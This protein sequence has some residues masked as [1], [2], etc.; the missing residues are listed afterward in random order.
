MV[1]AA[2]VPGR[3]FLPILPACFL[4]A[5]ESSWLFATGRADGPLWFEAGAALSLIAGYGIGAW[6]WTRFAQRRGK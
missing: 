4:I 6:V 5:L 2:I 1:T 3:P